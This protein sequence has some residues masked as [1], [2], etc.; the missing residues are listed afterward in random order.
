M[1]FEDL[2]DLT[3]LALTP[4]SDFLPVLECNKSFTNISPGFDV[5]PSRRCHEEVVI[6]V[7]RLFFKT[8]KTP[9]FIPGSLLRKAFTRKN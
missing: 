9:I 1:I 7:L 4:Y 2:S 3:F 5:G 6:Q 8:T